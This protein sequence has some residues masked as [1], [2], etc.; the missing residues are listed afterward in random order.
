MYY[1]FSNRG[2]SKTIV[3]SVHCYVTFQL[4]LIQIMKIH[5]QY[6]ICVF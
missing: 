3:N 5:M 4:T 1:D 6:A 2:I